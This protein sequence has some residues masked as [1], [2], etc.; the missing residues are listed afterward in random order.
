VLLPEDEQRTL[1]ACAVFRGGFTKD[2]AAAVLG[3][4][5]AERALDR[6]LR[7]RDRSLIGSRDGGDG[8]VRLFLLGAVH[9][10]AEAKLGALPEGRTWLERHAAHYGSAL[11]A[12]VPR[13]DAAHVARIEKEAENLLAAA[14]R[15]IEG[16][17]VP[18]EAAIV[19]LIALEPAVVARGALGTFHTLLDRA[20]GLTEQADKGAEGAKP[21]SICTP[22]LA[23][24]VRQI[25]AR[26]DATSGRLL[27]ARED[28]ERCL[29]QAEEA[30]EAALR[31]S[32][33]L[34]L[35]VTHHFGRDLPAARACY[36]KALVLLR[37][38]GDLGSEGRCVGNLGALHH[39]QGALS[40]AARSYA[41][42][43][44]LL[45]QSGEVPRRAN[46]IGNLALL[47]Q[48]LGRLSD[49]RQLYQR[50]LALLESLRNARLLGITLGN[51]ALLELEAANPGAALELAERSLRLLSDGG[52]ARSEALACARHGVALSVLGRL[53]DA[54]VALS[55]AERLLPS[56][57]SL[58]REVVSL[59]RAFADVAWAKEARTRGNGS[60][61]DEL[62]LARERIERSQTALPGDRSPR[63]RSDDVRSL[64]RI[65]APLFEECAAPAR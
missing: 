64:L 6:L 24:R 61:A 15:G 32:V 31:G 54:E 63:D 5:S 49:A 65:I 10:Y 39:D 1:A 47:E 25:R 7:L 8:S 23:C 2:A 53:G 4:E 62:A 34:D 58:T 41:H 51:F 11:Y 52:D 59:A 40:L 21:Q 48:E 3:E 35:G 46:F 9:E 12:P 33:Y 42:A 27:R 55:R 56:A 28:L 43:I 20:V 36:E 19:A 37:E 18:V 22:A 44:A 14:E 50:A 30:G 38:A 45:E 17:D 13:V 57:D 26:L 29:S 60:G 16:D